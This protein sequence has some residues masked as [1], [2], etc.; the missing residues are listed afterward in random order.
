MRKQAISR[1]LIILL[2]ALQPILSSLSYWLIELDCSTVPTLALRMLLLTGTTLVAM[3][4]S[5]HRSRY[6]CLIA[7]GA[8]FYCLHAWSGF[9]A[10]SFASTS[11][12]AEDLTNYIRVFQIPLL[13]FALITL[14]ASAEGHMRSLWQGLTVAFWLIVLI[15]ILSTVTGTDPHTYAA[16]GIGVCGWFYAPS[17][18]SAVLTMLFPPVL[19]AAMKQEKPWIFVLTAVVGF[20]EL[21]LFATRLSYLAIF[22]IA[23]CAILFWTVSR[24]TAWWKTL[25]V[26]LLALVCGLCWPVS[27]MK[28]NRDRMSE[29][30]TLKQEQ[31][32]ALVEQGIEEFGSEGDEYLTYVYEYQLPNLVD[33]FGFEKTVEIYDHTALVSTIGNDRLKKRNYCQLLLNQ[34]P[35]TAKL[36]GIAYPEM[37]WNGE[38]FDVENDLYGIL[39]LY[40]YAGV[41]CL[42]GFLL[43]FAYQVL[44]LLRR[45]PRRCFTP[46]MG[47][48]AAMIACGMAHA[49]FTAGLLRRPNAS[50]YLS[51]ALAIVWNL[52]AEVRGPTLYGG[53]KEKTEAS[54]RTEF[55]Q[56]GEGAEKQ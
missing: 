16:K 11:A 56:D 53:N 5:R 30:A 48:A 13:T 36:F 26:L 19:Y 17:S 31:Y 51:A 32:D 23:A 54:A 14:T 52:T 9:Q 21:F 1:R 37:T 27:P 10:G 45:S 46:E 49:I 3:C 24:G 40:G 33:R 22:L 34:S 35:I 55:A 7:V 29:N 39:Y 38:V 8:G 12:L 2:C 44:K 43:F 47:A 4:F 41:L 50:F 6:I 42:L 18:Q 15:E 20:A 28:Q 25:L